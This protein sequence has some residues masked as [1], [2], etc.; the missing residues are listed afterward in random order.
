MET[1]HFIIL[2]ELNTINGNEFDRSYPYV[3]IVYP[4]N[5]DS[6]S[7]NNDNRSHLENG[8]ANREERKYFC[9]IALNVDSD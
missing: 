9:S 1:D 6:F 5:E 2:D 7:D 4:S 3:Q 8:L